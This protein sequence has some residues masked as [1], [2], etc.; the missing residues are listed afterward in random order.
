LQIYEDKSFAQFEE[1]DPNFNKVIVHIER[2]L[3]ITTAQTLAIDSLERKIMSLSK[4][5]DIDTND[6]MIPKK[7]IPAFGNDKKKDPQSEGEDSEEQ[8]TSSKM[9]DNKKEVKFCDVFTEI[10]EDQFESSDD[11]EEKRK[12]KRLERLALMAQQ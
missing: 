8:K 12:N 1:N 9:R 4:R 5:Q 6:L 11:G 2:V 3:K 10:K 7:N